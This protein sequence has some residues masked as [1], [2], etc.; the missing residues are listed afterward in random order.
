MLVHGIKDS[1]VLSAG[2]GLVM[3]YLM[4]LVLLASGG[5]HIPA[6]IERAWLALCC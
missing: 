6:G 3:V 5:L 2:A 4:A 1:N